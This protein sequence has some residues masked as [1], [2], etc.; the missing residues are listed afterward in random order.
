MTIEKESSLAD[1]Q[2][3]REIVRNSSEMTRSELVDAV[4]DWY[5]SALVDELGGK[6]AADSLQE[7]ADAL[8]VVS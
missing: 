7:T 3:L 8:R 4:G 2:R 1:R 6:E 5:L